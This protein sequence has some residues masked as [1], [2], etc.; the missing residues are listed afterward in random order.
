MTTFSDAVYQYGGVPVG[1]VFG[2]KR[3]IWV[4]PNIG[5][6]NNSGLKPS[7]AV[8]TLAQAKAIAKTYVTG[9]T[10]SSPT[11]GYGMTVYLVAS[12][13]TSGTPMGQGSF[14]TSNS[15][16]WD[17]DGCNLVGVNAFNLS[18]SRARVYN[19]ST[20]TCPEALFTLSANNCYIAN[21][22]FTHGVGSVAPTSPICVTVSGN[23]NT[24]E[25]C[26][27]AGNTDSGGTTDTAGARSLLVSGATDCYFKRC[28]IGSTAASR[29]SQAA[30]IE[31]TSSAGRIV[32]DDCYTIHKSG[33]AGFLIVKAD[34]ASS[35]LADVVEFVRCRMINNTLISGG[36]G[37]TKA[38]S[39]HASLASPICLNQCGVAGA[40]GI[41]GSSSKVL[42]LGDSNAST[43]ATQG[44]FIASAS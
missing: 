5:S 30:E 11:Y 26:K 13:N 43:A 44:L 32:F 2:T 3:A 39:A 36:T 6:D 37:L 31:F 38:I 25:N 17:I 27:I 41:S 8:Q 9:G 29:T 24:F 18:G 34:A 20:L 21:I 42:I 12:T 7:Q 16:T 28:W 1:G 22:D 4:D 23:Y 10:A 35:S 19:P 40:T 33:A 15:V 14:S